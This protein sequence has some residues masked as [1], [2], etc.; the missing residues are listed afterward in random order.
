MWTRV[1]LAFSILVFQQ[2][3]LLA[4]D[5]FRMNNIPVLHGSKQLL[6]PFT[7]GMNS[8][9]VNQMDLNNDGLKDLVVVHIVDVNANRIQPYIQKPNGDY[10]YSP[11]YEAF[12]PKEFSNL[13]I[14]HDLNEDNIDD[15]I[16]K[17]STY[18]LIHY[19]KRINDS[20]FQFDF[21][22]SLE[23]TS[24]DPSYG[25]QQ[26]TSI[27]KYQPIFEDLDSD[28]DVDMVYV[29][30]TGN[31]RWYYKNY[32]KELGLPANQNL[33]K[34]DNICYG[35]FR[36]GSGDFFPLKYSEGSCKAMAKGI[37]PPYKDPILTPRH[38]QYQMFWNIDV[39][40]DK[41]YDV[42]TYSENQRNSPLGINVGSKDSAY[43]VNSDVYFPSYTKPIGLMMPIGFWYDLNNDK[44]KD[45]LVSSLIERDVTGV[46]ISQKLFNDD[47]N[48]IHH[49][50]NVGKR[51]IID[52]KTMTYH[53]SFVFMTDSF[54]AKETIDV[55]TG[56][57]P[58]FYN[59]DRDSLIDLLIPNIMKRDSWEIG[60]ITYYKNIG[61]K[62][63][64]I[65]KLE[66]TDLFRY[67]SKNRANIK[68]AVGD[69]NGDKQD[70]LLITSYD[71][72]E[73]GPFAR[74]GNAN[75]IGEI[76]Y[77]QSA[78]G[79]AFFYTTENLSLDT[80]G[81]YGRSNIC[82]YDV[83][84]DGK[85]DLFVGD[86][87]SIKYYRN[88]GTNVT[89]LYSKASCDTVINPLDIVDLNTLPSFAPYYQPA[90]WKDPKDKKEYLI[91]AYEHYRGKVGKAL[92]D[93]QKLNNNRPL[94]LEDKNKSIYDN[95]S[96]NILP[97]IAIKDITND[98]LDEI[99][100][101]NYAGGVQIFSIDSLTGVKDPPRP[102]SSIASLS[103]YGKFRIIPNPSQDFIRLEGLE[104]RGDYKLY[105][106]SVD[107]R[108]VLVNNKYNPLEILD[109]SQL[110][111]GIYWV[112]LYHDKLGEN[113]VKLQKQ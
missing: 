76:Y 16:V 85:S 65:Y 51:K 109:I 44:A 37:T 33:W 64:P 12:F 47:I 46:Q 105:I 73:Y 3:S 29:N 53:D 88:V 90:V 59:Y 25:L 5:L 55:G 58:V 83:D 80:E 91:F 97:S 20:T 79:G 35:L 74:E 49:Y 82:I 77:H 42:V 50:K 101:G 107:G 7:G 10:I 34:S 39:N 9:I 86:I 17:T 89:P 110:N 106:F 13:F 21:Y 32:K 95:Y 43:I 68:L 61:N 4:Q 18:F 2:F 98:S 78:P 66:D 113:T 11:R 100:F 28:G 30:R 102:P 27:N 57:A 41:L 24:Y 48:T 67:K 81:K 45:I 36:F 26:L 31:N 19:S 72:L 71:R 60:Y 96:F 22:D 52:T 104:N 75:I 23:Y 103:S 14:L 84:K 54:L 8:S 40:G 69:L 112:K 38:D 93:T 56:S 6:N 111:T 15:L 87:Y 108:L 63:Q 1:F 70:D 62:K 99:V 94:I 92:I